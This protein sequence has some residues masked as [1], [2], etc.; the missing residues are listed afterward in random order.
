MKKHIILLLN[1]FLSFSIFAQINVAEAK[2]GKTL[3]KNKDAN[4]VFVSEID[5]AS[6]VVSRMDMTN[7]DERIAYTKKKQHRR[8][9]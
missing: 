9:T 2:L 1:A 7:I 6:M 3:E 4:A 8:K 5:F